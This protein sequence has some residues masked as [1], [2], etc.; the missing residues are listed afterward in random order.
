[1]INRGESVSSLS[2][3]LL[4]KFQGAFYFLLFE[5]KRLFG[6]QKSCSFRKSEAR[7][8]IRTSNRF[9]L[10]CSR[11]FEIQQIFANQLKSG[12]ENF[13]NTNSKERAIYEHTSHFSKYFAFRIRSLTV[14]ACLHRTMMV[15]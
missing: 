4:K 8:Q 3:F 6:K 7:F 10:D 9:Q 5:H 13:L 11:R 15:A 14:T 12:L 1:M 2:I